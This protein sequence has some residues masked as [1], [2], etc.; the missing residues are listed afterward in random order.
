M[1][2]LKLF[3]DCAYNIHYEEVGKKVNYQFVEEEDT[4]YIYFQCSNGIIDWIRNFLF[5]KKVYGEF[6]VHRGFLSA[7]NEVRDIILDKVYSKIYKHVIIVGYSHGGALCTLAVE[8]IAYHF[9]QLDVKGYAFESPRCV[10]AKKEL[11]E[12]W[13]DLIVIRNGSDL[14]T[15]LPPKLFGF[16]D[17]GKM[18]KIKGDASLVKKH[19]PKCIKYH[20]PEVV[21]DGLQKFER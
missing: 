16:C 18:T 9:P 11:R 12:R 6:K 1:N 14:I 10:S 4:L 7:Y 13:K 5:K 3:E 15:H 20:Y 8:D 21:I 2:L 19:I 17:L